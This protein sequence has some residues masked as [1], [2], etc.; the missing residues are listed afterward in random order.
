MRTK[1][2]PRR[3][4]TILAALLFLSI[5]AACALWFFPQQILT[6]D[7]GEVKAEVIIIPGGTPDRAVR[8][9]ELYRQGEAPFILV[10]GCGDC[11]ASANYLETNGVPASHLWLESKS[12]TTRENARLSLAI[13]Q[14]HHIK[15]AILVTSW[16]HSRRVL[17]CFEHYAP[18]IQ[19]YSRPSYFGYPSGDANR[20][21]VN[22]YIKSEYIKLLGYWVCYGVCPI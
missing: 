12:E 1:M 2:R 6:V 10:S 8:A 4:I 7:S 13:L 18:E 20:K 9:A 21:N 11:Q 19:F 5:A 14:S 17:H 16:Y 3:I 22:P 15:S